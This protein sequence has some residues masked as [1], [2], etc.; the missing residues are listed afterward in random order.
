[1]I[2]KQTKKLIPVRISKRQWLHGKKGTELQKSALAIG[3]KMCCL[4]FLC[5]KVYG[6][7]KK[8]MQG[9]SYPSRISR[10]IREIVGIGD[11]IPEWMQT[12][13]AVNDYSSYT[14]EKRI[15]LIK[16][17]FMANGYKAI[18]VK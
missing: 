4:G 2:A 15:K 3:N 11:Y 13:A 6:I 16:K 10:E 8:D 18:F 5:E 14:L 1:M 7:T 17:L 9:I 12:A